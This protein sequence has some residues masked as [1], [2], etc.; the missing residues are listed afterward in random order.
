MVESLLKRLFCKD[1]FLQFFFVGELL[2]E[3]SDPIERPVSNVFDLCLEKKTLIV[4]RHN[5]KKVL[6]YQLN[7]VM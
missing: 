2:A 6:F 1:Y 5:E 7:W 3:I 4:S